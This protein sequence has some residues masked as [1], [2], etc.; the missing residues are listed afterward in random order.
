MAAKTKRAAPRAPAATSKRRAPAGTATKPSPDPRSSA[1]A[2]VKATS[3]K[4]GGSY[5]ARIAAFVEA[6]I[7]N[8]GNATQAAITAGY[9]EKT[10]Y[11]QGSRLLKNVEVAALVAE[12]RKEALADLRINTD[13]VLRELSRIVHF[14]PRKLYK[15][16][17]TMKAIHE[18]DDDTAAA[19]ASVEFDNK[20]RPTK[21]RGWDKNSALGNAM[22]HLGLLKPEMPLVPPPPP[23]PTI[24]AQNVVVMSPMEAYQRMLRSATKQ[25]G[26]D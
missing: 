6:L 23:G 5:E 16:D 10:A 19:I 4:E 7:A 22:R 9:S 17:G 26:A 25:P 2:I 13:N 3:H 12:R 24:H 15:P 21:V 14:D 20:G 1:T 11:S 8:G 18:L